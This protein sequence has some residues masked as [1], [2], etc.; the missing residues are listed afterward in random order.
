MN[1]KIV[2]LSGSVVGSKPELLALLT[3]A[4]QLADTLDAM[5][6]A[7]RISEAIDLMQLEPAALP[8]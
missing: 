3:S 2:P 1:D 7:I 8:D 5:D 6:V 4:L